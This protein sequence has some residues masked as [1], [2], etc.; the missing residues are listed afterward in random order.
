MFELPPRGT[1]GGVFNLA[2]FQE[3][4]ANLCYKS[5]QQNYDPNIHIL[6]RIDRSLK[7]NPVPD[8]LCECGLGVV[9]CNYELNG[10]LRSVA[11]KIVWE[12]SIML[13]M[14]NTKRNRYGMSHIDRWPSYCHYILT[15]VRRVTLMT[16][17]T[18]SSQVLTCLLHCGRGDTFLAC[19]R[20]EM[21][22]VMKSRFERW[23]AHLA[24]LDD[25][26]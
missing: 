6:D 22:S 5:I 1:K 9:L 7:F 13:K 16:S 3:A 11:L 12:A 26:W 19:N 23:R 15:N 17:S 4:R 24:I 8:S 25:K 21:R 20:I 10:S 2:S 18:W 14:R